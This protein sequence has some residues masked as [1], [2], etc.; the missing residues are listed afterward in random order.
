MIQK[1]VIL[2][3]LKMLYFLIIYHFIPLHLTPK[4]Q[5]SYLPTFTR[6]LTPEAPLK[7]YVHHSKPAATIK[8][9]PDPSPLLDPEPSPSCTSLPNPMLLQESTRISDS[10]IDMAFQHS[11][12]LWI[13]FLFL[14][15]H[16]LP[17]SP[18]GKRQW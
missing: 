2:A 9:E 3:F 7:V 10:L 15:T 4:Y 14:L 1:L 11:I 16:K 13:L 5:V 18:V 12:P 8:P 6:Q 17:K